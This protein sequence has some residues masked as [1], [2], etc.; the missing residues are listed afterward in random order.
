[1]TVIDFPGREPSSGDRSTDEIHAEAYRDLEP[2]ICDCVC[3]GNIAAQ[4]LSDAKNDDE[5][6]G[7]AVFQLQD[8]LKTRARAIG[9]IRLSD[10]GANSPIGDNSPR[11]TTQFCGN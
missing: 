6:L 4:L 7:F 9:G 11:R 1:M 5:E 2:H 3:M 8:M 10:E